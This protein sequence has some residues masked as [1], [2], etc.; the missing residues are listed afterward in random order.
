MPPQTNQ[1]KAPKQ[2]LALF[3]HWGMF[4][5][6]NLY[7]LLTNFIPFLDSYLFITTTTTANANAMT[8][9]ALLL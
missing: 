8:H 9:P 1:C 3:G 7:F 4:V 5:I 6:A 2:R